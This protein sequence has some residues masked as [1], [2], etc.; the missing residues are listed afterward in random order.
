MQ[1]KFAIHDLRFTIE[2]QSAGGTGVAP[3]NSGVA[4][5][6]GQGSVA[7]VH[8]IQNGLASR[9]GFGRD[10]R[11]NRRDACSTRLVLNP[12]CSRT[13]AAGRQSSIANHKSR[14]GV[15]LVL[16]LILLSVTLVMALAFLAI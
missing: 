2:R 7:G 16:T 6:L 9:E 5:E 15:A 1:L 14:S 13:V 10:A 3:V 12:P 4:P 8:N 11:N